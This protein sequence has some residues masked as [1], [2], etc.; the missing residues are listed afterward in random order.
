M[1]AA[2]A[3]SPVSAPPGS[4]RRALSDWR[5][6]FVLLSLIWGMSFLFIKIGAE[7]LSPVQLSLG[8]MATGALPLLAVLLL[9]G[10][11]LPR[12]PRLWGHMFVAALLLN[13]VPFTLFGYAA[14]L[15]PS[16]LMG[17]VNAS[18]P[19]FGVVFSMLLLS[20]ERP[21]RDRVLGLGI[22]FLGVLTVFG[23]WR[24]L[25]EVTVSDGDAV[26]GMLFVVG[27]TVCYGIGTPYLRRFVA[28][29]SHGA[30]E[31]S[32]LQLLLGSV[33]LVV[34]VPLFTEMPTGVTW[35]VV[36]AVSTL[37]VFGTGVAY[38]LQYAVVREAGATVA[39]T[40]TYVAPVVAIAAGVVLLDETLSWNQPLGAVVIILGA[41]LC[42]GVIRTRY[43]VPSAR[44]R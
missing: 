32:T 15:I 27:A 33:P 43:V 18:T 39:T 16:A 37:G 42:Q 41:A 28:G 38:I 14:Q 20:D 36:A 29:S 30:L 10:G 22:G 17:I 23:V 21:D 8:R 40:V 11:R 34:L 31:L 24:S 5:A 1:S 13:T 25:D 35:Q 3:V 9:R 19:L 12:S 26:L 2:S 6:K 4:P 7:V 44:R